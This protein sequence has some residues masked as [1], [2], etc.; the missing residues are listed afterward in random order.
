[1]RLNCPTKYLEQ[2]CFTCTVTTNNA[3][4]VAWHHRERCIFYNETATNFNRNTLNLE[5]PFRVSPHMPTH[6]P[7][8]NEY[9]DLHGG[10]GGI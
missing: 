2:A 10:R 5:H 8:F 9:T 6:N 4:F 3:H 1:M 7:Q